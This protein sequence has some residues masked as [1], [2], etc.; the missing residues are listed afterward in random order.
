MAKVSA[1]RLNSVP[2]QVDAF[3]LERA[4]MVTWNEV[5]AQVRG[6]VG[7]STTPAHLVTRCRIA[8][9]LRLEACCKFSISGRVRG[10]LGAKRRSDGR[11]IEVSH[12][13]W[14]QRH[15]ASES[16]VPSSWQ[17]ASAKKRASRQKKRAS[18]TFTSTTASHGTAWFHASRV[19][20]YVLQGESLRV[21]S[22]R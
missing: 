20:L 19:L 9:H 21:E 2:A 5:T 15:K 22:G 14:V 11:I 4:W 13:L 16:A 17:K 6:P 8:L 1:F 3:R 12:Q 7:A 18:F 10:W